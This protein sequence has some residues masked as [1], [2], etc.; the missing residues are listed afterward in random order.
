MEV[1][2]FGHSCFLVT[3]AGKQLLFDPFITPNELAKDINIGEIKADYIILSHGHQD[4]I[5][6]V[7]NIYKNNQPQII[8]TFEVVSWFANKGLKNGHSMN[9]GGSWDFDFGTLKM[10]NAVHSSSM[11]DGS[12]GGNPAGF[13]IK[14]QN[15]AFYYAGD[16]ALHYDMK[17]IEDEFNI[18]FAF[19]PIGS[20]FTMGIEDANKAADFVGTKK[21]IGMH[22]DTFPLIKINHG[23]AVS[24]FQDHGKELVLMGIGETINL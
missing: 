21:V 8:S 19:L 3:T 4:H 20:N 6:D 10:V 13:V 14:S 23:E 5:A 17:L 12:Y 7:E 2:Y 1:T 9:H 24:A 16:T 15:K 22:Y 18:D 11:P